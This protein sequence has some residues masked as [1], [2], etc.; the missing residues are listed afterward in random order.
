MMEILHE[1]FEGMVISREVVSKIMRFD[2]TRLFLWS[3]LELQAYGT[4]TW[5]TPF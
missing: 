1:P 2:P 4:A 3:F 5:M